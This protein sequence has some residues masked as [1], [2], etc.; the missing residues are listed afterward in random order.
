MIK[1]WDNRACHSRCTSSLPHWTDPSRSSSSLS[2]PLPL[3]SFHPEVEPIV[4]CHHRS[5]DESPSWFVSHSSI[6]W[7]CSYLWCDNTWVHTRVTSRSHPTSALPRLCNRTEWRTCF[8][9]F[10]VSSLPYSWTQAT[11]VFASHRIHVRSTHIRDI[12]RSMPCFPQSDTYAL[13]WDHQLVSEELFVLV[14]LLPP[15]TSYSHPYLVWHIHSWIRNGLI[16]ELPIDHLI[17]GCQ[18]LPDLSVN[19]DLSSSLRVDSIFVAMSIHLYIGDKLFKSKVKNLW[20]G[21]S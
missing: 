9:V 8:V 17:L 7:T 11:V 15:L 6:P 14:S 5:W 4:F 20:I 12:A 3:R 10:D 19:L 18:S 16:G 13:L 21:N 2:V 1:H